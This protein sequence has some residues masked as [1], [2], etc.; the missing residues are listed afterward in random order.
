MRAFG[1][2][3]ECAGS[4]NIQHPTPTRA[5]EVVEQERTKLLLDNW[6]RDRT[7]LSLGTNDSTSHNNENY[8]SIPIGCIQRGVSEDAKT[9][10]FFLV[11]IIHC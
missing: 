6:N 9:S 11:Q 7:S 4:S 2:T 3:K 8:L 10:V 1:G 5:A